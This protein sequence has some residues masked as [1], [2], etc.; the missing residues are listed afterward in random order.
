MKSKS[1]SQTKSGTLTPGN[2]SFVN[3]ETTFLIF[4]SL[5]TLLI[6]KRILGHEFL[7]YDDLIYVE[8][9]PSI[10]GLTADNIKDIFSQHVLG[11]YN[12]L[13]FLIY[14]I[15]YTLWGL[16]PKFFHLVNLMLHL[17]ATTLCFYF[18]RNLS[19]SN[20]VA[21]ITCL[22]FALH[23]MHVSSVA[24]IAQTKTPLFVSLYFAGLISYLRQFREG[25]NT[26][27]QLRSAFIFQFLALLA[28]P[29]AVTFAP[30]LLAV[31]FWMNRKFTWQ[32]LKEKI[33]FFILSLGFGIINI[34]THNASGD[35]IF[36]VHHH[37]SLWEKILIANYGICFYFEKLLFPLNLSFIYPYP[38]PGTTFP[39]AY[40]YT[41]PVLPLLAFAVL[42]AKTLRKELIFGFAFFAIAVSVVLRLMPAGDFGMANNYSYLSYTG[43]FLIMASFWN[44]YRTYNFSNQNLKILVIYIIPIAYLVGLIYTTSHRITKYRN[45]TIIMTDV[46]EKYP[47]FSMAYSLRAIHKANSGD[48]NG[49][50]ADFGNFIEMNPNKID[51]YMNRGSV[52][53]NMKQL[54][55][56]LADMQKCYELEPDNSGV[57]YNLGMIYFKM[58]KHDQ[59]LPYFN[60]CLKLNPEMNEALY[61]RGCI[62]TESKE[63]SKAYADLVKSDDLG[64]PDAKA[65]LFDLEAKRRKA[66]TK[67]R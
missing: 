65:A 30:M 58:E 51:G 17:T 7:N 36:E 11:M 64:N 52:Y 45:S 8:M 13:P 24:W 37:Y 40:Y 9:N 55:K 26:T 49:S 61:L 14:A 3:T 23:P 16:N 63:F 19:N 28:K 67:M 43:L 31:D 18:V 48:I 56:A 6:F 66:E 39:M 20:T 59:A 35:P 34:L 27:V 62:F 10:K 44:R 41:L 32:T 60:E 33:P 21:M 38:L 54:D 46:I 53:A 50:L 47:H 5:L 1:R 42:K 15:E 22:L 4:A 25:A 29:S 12:P 2:K 57:C